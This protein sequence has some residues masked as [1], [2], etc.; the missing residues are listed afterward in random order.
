MKV[1]PYSRHLFY[2]IIVWLFL[3]VDPKILHYSVHKLTLI[4]GVVP[5]VNA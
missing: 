3:G 2:I 5:S 4:M 1:N